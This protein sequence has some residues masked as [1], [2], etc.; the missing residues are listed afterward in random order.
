MYVW[1]WVCV[2]VLQWCETKHDIEDRVTDFEVQFQGLYDVEYNCT[3][4]F[5]IFSIVC[6]IGR[7]YGSSV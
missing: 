7:I 5:F 2:Y 3:L 1:V 6:C 4:V